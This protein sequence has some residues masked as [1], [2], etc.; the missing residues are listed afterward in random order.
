MPLS[1]QILAIKGGNLLKRKNCDENLLK[2]KRGCIFHLIFVGVRPP[3]ILILSVNNRDGGGGGWVLLNGKNLLSMTKVI[4]RQSL[5][6]LYI[7]LYVN[8]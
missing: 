5:T 6:Y 1:Y 3:S 2:C 8:L 7:W 4:C